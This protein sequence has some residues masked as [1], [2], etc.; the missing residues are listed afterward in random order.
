MTILEVAELAGVERKQIR[1]SDLE[2]EEGC[3]LVTTCSCK[4][5]CSLAQVKLSLYRNLLL[6]A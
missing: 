5:V 3:R 2:E 4:L 1:G 6:T